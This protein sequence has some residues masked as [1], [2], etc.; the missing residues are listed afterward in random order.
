MNNSR[1]SFI[2]KTTVALAGTTLFSNQLFAAYATNGVT[3]LQLYSVRD[4]MK[5]NPLDTLQ[6]LSKMGYIYVEH[7]N[8]V[9]RKFYGY[10]AT[11][12]KK[13]L[14][15]LGLKMPSGHTVMNTKDWDDATKDFT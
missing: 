12:F 3:G 13:V 1:R 4:D 8:Y 2:K 11:D 6:Q 9:D 14:D 15:D 7:A 10:S 5:A